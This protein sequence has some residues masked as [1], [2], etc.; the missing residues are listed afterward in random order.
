MYYYS[1]AF[2]NQ[3]FGDGGGGGRWQPNLVQAIGKGIVL[4]VLVLSFPFA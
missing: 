1:L 2:I 3:T 4:V